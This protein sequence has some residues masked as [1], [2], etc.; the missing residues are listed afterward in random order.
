M[1]IPI[2]FSFSVHASWQPVK[3]ISDKRAKRSSL[4]TSVLHL[5]YSLHMC[6][7]HDPIWYYWSVSL[8]RSA[9]MWIYLLEGNFYRIYS[10]F[11]QKQLECMH[12]PIRI[13]CFYIK[14]STAIYQFTEISSESYLQN[15]IFFYSLIDFYE[16]HIEFINF[17]ISKLEYRQK[18][19]HSLSRYDC[20]ETELKA[21]CCVV[22]WVY[23]NLCTVMVIELIVFSYN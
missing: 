4:N 13:E 20:L 17:V 16:M 5:Q 18:S 9:C 3:N 12:C 1:H 7:V 8:H 22:V 2:V 23:V 11:P 10:I 6:S 15:M 21:L 14:C 19:E